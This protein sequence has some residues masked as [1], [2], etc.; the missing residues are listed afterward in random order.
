MLET[1]AVK[2]ESIDHMFR[3]DKHPLVEVRSED[4]GNCPQSLATSNPLGQPADGYS[5]LEDA[6]RNRTIPSLDGLRA[7]FVG[8]VL[9]G[10][11]GV[12]YA[13][14][15]HGVMGFFVLSG[16]LITWLLLGRFIAR[17]RSRS[18]HLLVTVE[19]Q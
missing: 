11:L 16:F 14:A 12:P 8:V 10:H 17:A 1:L 3:W 9:L 2:S 6:L 18:A 7:I 19:R 15:S 4:A 13:P 5:L